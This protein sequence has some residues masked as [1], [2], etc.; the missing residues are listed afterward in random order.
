VLQVLEGLRAGGYC[1]GYQ[2]TWGSWPGSWPQDWMQ[3]PRLQ[4]E[5]PAGTSALLLQQAGNASA[6]AADEAAPAVVAAAAP[7]LQQQGSQLPG[8]LAF[9]VKLHQPADIEGSVALRQEEDG[10]WGHACS[11]LLGAVL[12]AGGWGGEGAGGAVDGSVTVDEFFYQDVWSGPASLGDRVLL[13]L[14]DPLQRV[15]VPF[16]PQ[17]LVQNWQLG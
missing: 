3:Q 14:G 5:L 15:E 4:G 9:Q 17:T 12:E 6:L 2:V 10:F 11:G 8:P 1:C 16:S 13:L 7:S